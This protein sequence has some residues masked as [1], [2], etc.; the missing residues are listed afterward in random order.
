MLH[1]AMPYVALQRLV[2]AIEMARNG[3]RHL[4]AAAAYFA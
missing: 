1:R 2:M 4:F 3:R